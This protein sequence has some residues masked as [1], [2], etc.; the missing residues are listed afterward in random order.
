M[1]PHKQAVTAMFIYHEQYAAQRS[2]CIEFWESLSKSEKR[3]C[4]DLINLIES[5]PE[6]NAPVVP[7]EEVR[8]RFWQKV[9][10]SD[11]CWLWNGK[12]AK[13]R[14]HVI[15]MGPGKKRE[16]VHR[17]SWMIHYGEIPLRLCVLHK[18]DVP[19]CVRPDHLFVGTHKDNSMDMVKKGRCKPRYGMEQKSA[20]LT[21]AQVVSLR[22]DH[23]VG[24]S[25][26]HLGR[27]YNVSPRTASKISKRLSRIYA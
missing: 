15:S 12:K 10:K 6:Y 21:W 16:G 23:A 24:L 8:E 17:I 9:R 19:N 11:G 27:K 2:G 13:H 14:Y 25:F 22:E 26:N 18:C 1:K 5:R 3:V 20:K 7:S 4:Q